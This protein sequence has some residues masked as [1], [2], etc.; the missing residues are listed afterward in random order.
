MLSLHFERKDSFG[1]GKRDLLNLDIQ[2]TEMA[3]NVVKTHFICFGF[4]KTCKSYTD[5]SCTTSRSFVRLHFRLLFARFAVH[6]FTFHS[7]FKNK[8]TTAA[9]AKST[10]AVSR[11]V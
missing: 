1:H 11:A 2:S 10:M 9:M 5:V 3:R 4:K 8:Q 6:S 7:E